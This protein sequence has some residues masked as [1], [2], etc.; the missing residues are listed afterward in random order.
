MLDTALRVNYC[1]IRCHGSLLLA[2]I[3]IK[4]LST[5]QP[6]MQPL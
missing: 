3:E 6:L 4:S 1:E 2:G 5:E